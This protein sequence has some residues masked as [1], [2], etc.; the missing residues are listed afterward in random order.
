MFGGGFETV[1]G[2]SPVVVFVAAVVVATNGE[3]GANCCLLAHVKSVCERTA[4]HLLSL[5]QQF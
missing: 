2:L 4:H 3:V 5:R 1:G